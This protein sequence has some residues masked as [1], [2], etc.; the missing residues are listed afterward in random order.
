M[1]TYKDIAEKAGV[2]LSTV[3]RA[4]RGDSAVSA[5]TRERVLK[6]ARELGYPVEQSA[7]RQ[8]PVI[9]L[10]CPEPWEFL[11]GSYVSTI[12]AGVMKVLA[13]D[14]RSVMLVPE[15][16]RETPPHRDLSGLILVHAKDRK[17]PIKYLQELEIPFVMIANPNPDERELWE[18]CHW[19]DIDHRQAAQDVVKYLYSLGHRRIAAI[20]GDTTRRAANE[21]K[22]GYEEAMKDCGL[23]TKDLMRGSRFT[24]EDGEASM[25]ALLDLAEPPTGI[26]AFSDTI[27]IG[28]A[29]AIREREGRIPED[30]SLVGFDN[31]L[32]G[33][34]ADPPL[35]TVEHRVFELGVRAT[36]LLLRAIENPE[37]AKEHIMLPARLVIRESCRPPA[38]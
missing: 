24:A 4:L 38:K 13:R 2:A 14:N 23:D 8:E 32:S 30:F 19:I 3:S 6:A 17:A 36:E 26:F 29:K 21:R 16:T 35:T 5:T 7:R 28:A 10:T 15:I 37:I 27:A 25:N 18:D 9:G 11:T 34:F 33:L 1:A 12:M 22:V 20:V 31:R